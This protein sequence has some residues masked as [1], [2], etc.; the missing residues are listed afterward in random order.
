MRPVT[1]LVLLASTLGFVDPQLRGIVSSIERTVENVEQ[2]VESFFNFG[3][4][5]RSERTVEYEEIGDLRTGQAQ[6]RSGLRSQV[7]TASG[8]GSGQVS[9][10]FS[11]GLQGGGYRASLGGGRAS[12][13]GGAQASLSAG[14]QA[15]R[16]AGGKGARS[17]GFQRSRRGVQQVDKSVSLQESIPRGPPAYS[18][19]GWLQVNRTMKPEGE[20]SYLAVTKAGVYRLQLS[21][22]PGIQADKVIGMKISLDYWTRFEPDAHKL[23]PIDIAIRPCWHSTVRSVD[24]ST[25]NSDSGGWKT[26]SY[27]ASDYSDSAGD[28]F[29]YTKQQCLDEVVIEVKIARSASD[30]TFVALKN[31]VIEYDITASEQSSSGSSPVMTIVRRCTSM[32]ECADFSWASKLQMRWSASSTQA[33][34]FEGTSYYAPENYGDLLSFQFSNLKET[35]SARVTLRYWVSAASQLMISPYADFGLSSGS[36]GRGDIKGFSL[37]HTLHEGQTQWMDINFWL[38]DLHPNVD[39]ATNVTVYM[40]VNTADGSSD[41]DT[42]ALNLM[43]VEWLQRNSLL[44]ESAPKFFVA[45]DS[46]YSERHGAW[47][48]WPSKNFGG[49]TGKSHNEREVIMIISDLG[50]S[51]IMSEWYAAEL[52]VELNLKY[53]LEIRSLDGVGSKNSIVAELTVVDAFYNVIY[54][55]DMIAD[56]T[57]QTITIP[58]L[59]RDDDQDNTLRRVI[60]NIV[61]IDESAIGLKLVLSRVS[62]GDGCVDNDKLCVGETSE[63]CRHGKRANTYECVCKAGFSGRHCSHQDFCEKFDGYDKCKL[64]G[65]SEP[66]CR[67]HPTSEHDPPYDCVCGLNQYWDQAEG[68]CVKISVCD[69]VIDCPIP[70][71]K[72]DDSLEREI[73]SED[74]LCNACIQGY[75]RVSN[76]NS[77]IS[78]QPIDL[79][80]NKGTANCDVIEYPSGERQRVIWCPLGFRKVYDE[81]SDSYR[82]ETQFEDRCPDII[83]T[84]SNCEHGCRISY[85]SFTWAVGRAV[86][87]LQWLA[88]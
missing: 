85:N 63:T 64:G 15:G 22:L 27:I 54:S 24:P 44:T 71:T 65:A 36:E 8:S 79:C 28:I 75:E 52:G 2:E 81:R 10:E 1:G 62:L 38:S 68:A 35:S 23:S 5:G 58:A 29:T 61:A 4:D 83:R 74:T 14:G 80:R 59:S 39:G 66:Y 18:L 25:M 53:R 82:C 60:F 48:T 70:F 84:A 13:S 78:C 77:T 46:V 34:P 6:A 31:I 21:N 30:A 12:S 67:S 40:K 51:Y 7:R 3:Q 11:G 42:A 86:H 57:D 16:K 26:L 43:K 56:P 45:W 76:S 9:M 88:I 47:T 19:S 55:E 69:G 49:E 87:L 20:G 32:S 41:S 37:Y 73:I 72:C 50:E 17:G 33:I